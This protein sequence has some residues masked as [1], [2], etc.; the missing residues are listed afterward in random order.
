MRRWEADRTII[1]GRRVRFEGTG[2][3]LFFKWIVWTFP[4]YLDAAAICAVTLFAPN[5]VPLVY[6]IT[7]VFMIIYPQ[8]VRLQARRWNA[9]RTFL[10]R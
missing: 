8:W 10:N 4:I 3:G 6:A 9:E 2:D 1:S 7:L 5:A